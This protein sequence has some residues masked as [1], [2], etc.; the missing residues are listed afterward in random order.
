MGE[1]TDFP[2]PP[3]AGEVVWTA[4][5]E[6]CVRV[7]ALTLTGSVA[8]ASSLPLSGPQFPLLQNGDGHINPSCFLMLFSASVRIGYFKSLGATESQQEA[9]VT[10]LLSLNWE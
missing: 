3:G 2:R 7:L 5:P 9:F 6:L 8:L 1:T 4:S 10:E